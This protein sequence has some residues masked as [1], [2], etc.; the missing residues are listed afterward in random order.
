MPFL[1]ETNDPT[2]LPVMPVGREPVE[3]RATDFSDTVAAAFRQDNPLVSVYHRLS[4]GFFP[5][6]PDHNPLDIVKD[7]PFEANHLDAFV[8][9]R[10][11]AE[12]LSIMSRIEREN[13]DRRILESAGAAGVVAQIAAGL[14]DPT[15]ALP[16]GA[17]YKAA[18]GGYAVARSAASVGAA[19]LLQS[20]VSEAALQATQETRTA[21]ETAMVIGSSTLLGA[22]IGAGASALLSRAERVALEKSLDA[23][24]AAMAAHAT[25]QPASAGAAATDERDLQ[26]VKTGLEFTSFVSPTRRVMSSESVAARRA[27]ADL[28]ETPYRFADNEAGVATTQGAAL[29]RLARIQTVGAKV[30]VADEIDR[31]FSEYRF[32]EQ[33]TYPRL[34][35]QFERF[36]GTDTGRL[37]HLQFKEEVGRAMREGDTHAIPQVQAAAQ[38]IR[39]RV[40]EPWKQRA[41]DLGLLPEGVSVETAASYFT[42]VYN[43]EAIVARRPEFLDRVTTYLTDDQATKAAAKERLIGLNDDLARAR[44]E[45]ARAGSGDAAVAAQARYDAARA[46]IE[47]EIA[48]WGGK[49]SADAKSAIKAR[50]KYDA[51]RQARASAKGEDAPSG[52]LRSADDAIDSTVKKIIESDRDLSPQELRAR[53]SEIADRILSS[54]DG[55]LPYDA[56]SGG[57]RIGFAGEGREP[58]RGPLAARQFAIPDKMI[59]E[60]LVSDVEEVAGVYLRTMV[61]DVLLTERFGDTLMTESFRKINEDY[62]RLAEAATSETRRRALYSERDRVIRDMAAMRDRVRHVYGWNPD[63]QNMARVANGLKVFNNLTSMGMAAISSIP[64]MAGVVFRHGLTTTFADGWAPYFGSLVKD[65]PAFRQFRSQMR[66]MGIGVETAINARQHTLDDVMDTYRPQSRFERALQAVNDKFFIA[67]LLAPLTD[68]TKQIAAHVATAEILRMARAVVDGKATG[69]Q[70]AVL[71]ENGIDRQMADRIWR[72]WSNGGGDV[73]DGVHLPNTGAWADNG[74]REAFEGA[75]AREVD[76]AVVT[77]GQEKPLLMSQPVMSLLLQFKSFVASANER[78]L[79]ANLQRRDAAVLSGIVVSIGLGM[80]AY[81]LNAVAGGTPT[82]ERPQDWIK[83]AISRGGM[84]GWLEE[85]NAMAA[86]MTRGSLDIYRVIGADRPLTRYASRNSADML[87]GPTAGKLSSL[88]QVTGAAGSGEWTEGDTKAVRRLVA[89]QN[90]FYL[91]HLLNEVE[92]GVND[93]FGIPMRDR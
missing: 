85:G 36:A 51:E 37:T 13:E 53:A 7:T 50:E 1:P 80:L 72:A 87:L 45:L 18:R 48:A 91:R 52:R 38:Y 63:M 30:Q 23:D 56:P 67:N 57:P 40:F 68:A 26:L 27:L 75:V 54:P 5:A 92:A 89:G 20:S 44:A 79:I 76:I 4:E 25:G 81:K 69:R 8:R 70:I 9:S 19:A 59:E 17:I 93:A 58:P 88:A 82:S 71:A 84:M 66:A 28:A 90:L 73:V 41:I 32:G 43:K 33:V 86:K 61:P 3:P 2:I 10:S 11:K 14:F 29:D 35:A 64:D 21:G 15:I 34:K 39:N 83:E 46:R 42:R 60:F 77:P 47:A 22:F 16:G 74:A 12:T 55:R 49:S 31:L 65:N 6:E 62:G 78:I 24:R